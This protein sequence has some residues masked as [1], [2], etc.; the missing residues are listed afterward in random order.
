MLSG[1]KGV[2][3]MD[4]TVG[5]CVI[6]LNCPPLAS[7]QSLCPRCHRS[8]HYQST[9][10]ILEVPPAALSPSRHSPLRKEQP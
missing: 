2:L 6:T 1:L 4:K 7:L 5:A 8:F 3:K 9:R 10:H